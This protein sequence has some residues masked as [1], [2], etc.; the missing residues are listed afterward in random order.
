MQKQP[1]S[2][3]FYFI[4]VLHGLLKAEFVFIGCGGVSTM[5]LTPKVELSEGDFFAENV[6]TL[7]FSVVQSSGYVK[8]HQKFLQIC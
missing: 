1:K 8:K 7:N 6:S 2:Y 3:V 5:E 4:S